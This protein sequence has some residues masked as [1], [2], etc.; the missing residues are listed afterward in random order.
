VLAPVQPK[1]REQKGRL[2]PFRDLS[3]R[4]RLINRVRDPFRTSK[5]ITAGKDD[6]QTSQVD[7]G[8]YYV[9]TGMYQ[10]SLMFIRFAERNVDLALQAIRPE[11]F[12]FLQN[13]ERTALNNKRGDDRYCHTVKDDGAYVEIGEL[14]GYPIFSSRGKLSLFL[15][16]DTLFKFLCHFRA[17]GWQPT[18]WRCLDRLRQRYP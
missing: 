14:R 13:R 1:P 5:M 3:L 10:S 4:T 8:T 12:N 18:T 2:P 11:Q 7:I 16:Y 9:T 15:L 6:N 17:S